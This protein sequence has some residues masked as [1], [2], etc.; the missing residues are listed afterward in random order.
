MY[1]QD[2]NSIKVTSIMYLMAIN[3]T[4]SIVKI[5]KALNNGYAY[6][7]QGLTACNAHEITNSK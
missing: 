4:N 6:W 2:Q 5:N 7:I 1:Y 3:E